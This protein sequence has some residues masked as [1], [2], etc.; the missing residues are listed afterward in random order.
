MSRAWS[1]PGSKQMDCAAGPTDPR[2][3]LGLQRLEEATGNN[4]QKRSPRDRRS[5]RSAFLYGPDLELG[6]RALWSS[7]LPPLQRDV[8]RWP[9]CRLFKPLLRL[10]CLLAQGGQAL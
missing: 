8:G 9:A 2:S 10:L 6:T 3:P 7:S 1:I 5:R 4:R